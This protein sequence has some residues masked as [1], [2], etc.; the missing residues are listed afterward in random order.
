M[1]LKARQ[2]SSTSKIKRGHHSASVL[3]DA[4][5]RKNVLATN[6]IH[7]FLNLLMKHKFMITGP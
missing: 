7:H 4:K 1:W 2:F 6:T 3:M 5:I